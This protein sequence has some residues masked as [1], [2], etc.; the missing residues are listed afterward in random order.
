MWLIS[1][2]GELEYI[3]YFMH[4]SVDGQVKY[5]R[6]WISVLCYVS[7]KATQ[8]CFHFVSLYLYLNF[9]CYRKLCEILVGGY[10]DKRIGIYVLIIG[11]NLF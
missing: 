3:K 10:Q 4:I 5:I 1:C 8:T 7:R 9:W 6:L 2:T 11:H